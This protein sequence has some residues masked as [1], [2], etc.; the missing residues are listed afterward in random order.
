M[1]EVELLT[2]ILK[3][4]QEFHFALGVAIIAIIFLLSMTT[5]FT[6]FKD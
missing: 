2:E 4:L 1:T 6:L 5:W 3:E